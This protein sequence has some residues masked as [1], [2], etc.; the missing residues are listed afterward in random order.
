MLIVLISGQ[1]AY[2]YFLLFAH[3]QFLKILLRMCIISSTGKKFIKSYGKK[4][5]PYN[6]RLL[7]H[8]SRMKC[9]MSTSGC[10]QQSVL[11]NLL[12]VKTHIEHHVRMAPMGKLTRSLDT[13]GNQ[14]ELALS[15]GHRATGGLM[16]PQPTYTRQ[17]AAQHQEALVYGIS[18]SEIREKSPDERSTA[19]KMSN[20]MHYFQVTIQDRKRRLNYYLW[21]GKHSQQVAIHI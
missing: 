4:Q 17:A 5:L 2:F 6:L 3:S 20:S 10:F 13:G 1:Y 21:P 7:N 14:P 11:P 12:H 16:G 18:K 8:S 15:E 19:L 9:L